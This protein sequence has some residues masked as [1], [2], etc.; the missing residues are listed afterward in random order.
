MTTEMKDLAQYL[1]V[2]LRC[3]TDDL[4]EGRLYS[5][6]SMLELAVIK[7]TDLRKMQ[8]ALTATQT[9][10]NSADLAAADEDA[11]ARAALAESGALTA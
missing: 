11:K 2:C 6:E 3:A 5:L 4:A 9:A 8:Q 7:A 10:P 1:K